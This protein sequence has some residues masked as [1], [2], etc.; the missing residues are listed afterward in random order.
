ML[1]AAYLLSKSKSRLII[2]QMTY[3]LLVL[4]AFA[5]MIS[6]C[7]EPTNPKIDIQ[8]K[9]TLQFEQFDSLKIAELEMFF[10]SLGS[11]KAFNGCYLFRKGMQLHQSCFGYANKSLDIQLQNEYRFQLA[12]VSK[13]LTALCFLKLYEAGLFNLDE[14]IRTY[15]TDF[16][17]EGISPAMLLSHT[18]G[19][20]N[21]MYLTDSLWLEA[22]VP[23]SVTGYARSER[24]GE[25]AGSIAISHKE[26]YQKI[27]L[28]KPSPYYLPGKKFSYCNTN[29]FLL[30]YLIEQ[31]LGM[32]FEAICDSIV[33]QPMGIDDAFWYRGMELDSLVNSA[34][35]YTAKY[36]PYVD[37]YLNGVIG[38]KGLFASTSSLLKL[39]MALEDGFLD[40][41]TYNLM[42]KKHAKTNRRGMHYGFGWRIKKFQGEKVVF[43]NGWWRGFRSYF[44]MIPSRKITIVVLTNSTMGGFL[45]NDAMMAL[46]N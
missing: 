24:I 21:Y 37:F 43:H 32:P 26:L 10:D 18:S 38:D 36:R 39:S 17:Y 27:I 3:G 30:A 23:D 19:L 1:K 13:P 42:T 4:I 16:P 15:L 29:Y 33:F 25:I 40:Q 28:E 5:G 11:R 31:E 45:K 44:M 22:Q 2:R 6:S 20:P 8:K 46:I 34:I 35:G 7:N 9:D 14:D 12:S 41:Q